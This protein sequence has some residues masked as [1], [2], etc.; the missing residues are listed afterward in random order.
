MKD[1]TGAGDCFTGVLAAAL[2]DGEAFPE[3]LWRAMLAAT[4]SCTREGAAVSFPDAEEI[5]VF[6]EASGA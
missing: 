1:T 5:D 6:L 2:D 3:A 4:L